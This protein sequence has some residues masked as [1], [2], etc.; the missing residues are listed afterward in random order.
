MEFRH[1]SGSVGL[2]DPFKRTDPI[3]LSC[4]LN[5]WRS[6]RKMPDLHAVWQGGQYAQSLPL[7]VLLIAPDGLAYQWHR[8]LP[9]D[10]IRSHHERSRRPRGQTHFSTDLQ[11]W[12]PPNFD[13]I[14]GKYWAYLSAPRVGRSV[15]R[16]RAAF[17]ME[18][19]DDARRPPCLAAVIECDKE[20]FDV[21]ED[22]VIRGYVKNIGARPFLL[23]THMPFREARLVDL[24]GDTFG[25]MDGTGPV[26]LSHF[27]RMEPGQR[28]QLFEET[29]VAGRRDPHWLIGSRTEFFFPP[30]AGP[31]R[32]I[33][34]RIRSEGLFPEDR[35]AP[36]GI[37][38]GD[39]KSNA[40]NIRIRR[41]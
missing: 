39:V 28:V 7:T 19:R 12:L 3:V 17:F 13:W 8:R 14:P 38:T 33:V 34:L 31:D 9:S 16:G 36:I 4:T 18:Q 32:T 23:Q 27:T 24:N 41:S 10:A 22:I 11:E 20:E 35:P 37:W 26:R 21:G 6:A 40:I 5:R 25:R 1:P 15:E 29:F 30:F 2:K